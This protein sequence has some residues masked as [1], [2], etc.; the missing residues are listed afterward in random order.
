MIL[1]DTNLLVFATSRNSPHYLTARRICEEAYQGALEACVSFQNLCEWYAVVT[2]PRK[3]QPA[4][5]AEEASRELETFLAP[6][7]LTILAFSPGILRRLPELLRRSGS[8][9]AH[10]FDVLLV[11][12]MLENGVETIYTENVS[13]FS[14]FREIRAINPLQVSR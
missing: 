2:H 13:D 10:A 1:L 5:S 8:R 9:G 3:V 14:A 12:T 4:L 11:A 6:S 7:R